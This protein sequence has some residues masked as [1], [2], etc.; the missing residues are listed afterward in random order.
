MKDT[1]KPCKTCLSSILKTKKLLGRFLDTCVFAY[2]TTQHE[3]TC[4]TPFELMFGR[5][6]LLPIDV[7]TEKKDVAMLLNEY[8]GTQ[9]LSLAKKRE[10]HQKLLKTAKANIT[11]AQQKQW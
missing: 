4:Y 3:S 7:N 5:K 11:K 2:N 10:V 9:N 1:T 6:P 8:H